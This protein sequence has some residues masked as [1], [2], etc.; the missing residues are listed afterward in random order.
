MNL[1][2]FFVL[3]Y[4]EIFKLFDTD[5]DGFISV[6]DLR[7]ALKTIGMSPSKREIFDMIRQG[8]GR[9]TLPLSTSVCIQY[10]TCNSSSFSSSLV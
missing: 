5:A 9:S 2:L 10:T 1:R 3:E 8:D 4:Q 6:P 7:T